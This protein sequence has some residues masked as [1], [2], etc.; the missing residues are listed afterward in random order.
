M[1][2]K[3]SQE[4]LNRIKAE[5]LVRFGYEADEFSIILV[6]VIQKNLGSIQN[7]V[8]ESIKVNEALTKQIKPVQLTTNKQALLL[9]L[10]PALSFFIIAS[11][12]IW[13]GCI[14]SDFEGRYRHYKYASE[15]NQF[16]ETVEIKEDAKGNSSIIL[17]PAKSISA[18][19]IGRNYYYNHNVGLVYVPI[20]KKR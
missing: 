20:V 4:E 17:R 9:Y 12:L 5:L 10:I 14:Y 2:S 11:I 13:L 3:I 19:R 18:A 7:T 16:L 8:S 1:K 15:I 6:D